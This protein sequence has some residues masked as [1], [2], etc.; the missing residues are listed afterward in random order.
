[1]AAGNKLVPF[2][3]AADDAAA[4]MRA[5]WEAAAAYYTAGEWWSLGWGAAPLG[6]LAAALAGSDAKQVG[7]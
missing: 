1:M 5:C 2:F 4:Q 7:V 6:A 3:S